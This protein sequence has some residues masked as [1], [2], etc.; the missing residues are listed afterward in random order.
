MIGLNIKVDSKAIERELDSL[1]RKQIPFARAMAVNAVAERVRTGEQANL[2]DTFRAPSPFT[3]NSLAVRKATKSN[4]VATVYVKPIAAKYLL[5]FETGGVHTLNSRA[6][7]N[8]KN[9]RL[10]RYG[11]LPRGMLA[12]LKGMPDV[13]VGSV[14]T[15]DGQTVNGI[16]QRPFLRGRDAQLGAGM[17]VRKRNKLLRG[18]HPDMPKNANTSGHL[19]LLV[20][21]GDAL[22]VN[23]RLGW[24]RL[25]KQIVAQHFNAELSKA[26]QKAIATAK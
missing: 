5:P 11:Q 12:K 9:V 23:K 10:N 8:P 21:F 13:F 20:R 19:R 24:G 6:L 7:L 4:P 3:V 1:A 18:A 14:K 25:A 16:W 17:T 15:K 2:K 26:L 22:P